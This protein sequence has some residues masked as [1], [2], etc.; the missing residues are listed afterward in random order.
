MKSTPA[1]W[2]TVRPLETPTAHRASEETP[3][4]GWQPA[5]GWKR[6]GKGKGKGNS[7]SHICITSGSCC[8]TT[9]SRPLPNARRT[10]GSPRRTQSNL[11]HCVDTVAR[12]CE[13]KPGSPAATVAQAGGLHATRSTCS[14]PSPAGLLGLVQELHAAEVR[15]AKGN[16]AVS[17]ELTTGNKLDGPHKVKDV[18][19]QAITLDV[20][21]TR[22]LV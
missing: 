17:D 12:R 18:Q 9:T 13:L 19:G 22:V 1:N 3:R 6:K 7:E 8:G 5:R 21:A 11:G 16:L 4:R 14:T 15:L 2:F 20:A 10:A